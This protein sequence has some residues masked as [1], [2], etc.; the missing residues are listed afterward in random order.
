MNDY[1]ESRWASE[2]ISLQQRDGSWGYFHSLCDPT[3]NMPMT[4][5]QALKRLQILGFTIDDEPIQRAVSYMHSCLAGDNQIPDR[6]EKLH[7]WDLFTSLMLPAWI[8]RF[9][10]EDRLANH[11]AEQWAQVIGYAFADGTYQHDSYVKA[12]TQVFKK[13]P[14]GG[15]FVDFV[16]FYVVSLLPGCLEE[17]I[18]EAMFDYILGHQAGIYYVYEKCILDVPEAFKSK[19]ASRYIGAIELLSE[20]KSPRCK[21]KLSFVAEWLNRSREPD[22][23]WDLSS[24]AKDGA[25]F[26]LSDS[27]RSE[28]TRKKD[29]TY[30]ISKLIR[31]LGPETYINQT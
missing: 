21:A 4:T 6:R 28:E 19:Q 31:T 1:K 22:G 14:R 11:K 5:E 13:A 26:P 20:Y 10:P 30:R 17:R 12:Y 29:C 18:E 27:W 8:R 2:I 16:T 23:T 15:R 3:K 24:A 9:T 25:Y 7:D